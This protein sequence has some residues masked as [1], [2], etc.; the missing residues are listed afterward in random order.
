MQFPLLTKYKNPLKS[1]V[2]QDV[3]R[4]NIQN[5]ELLLWNKTQIK[6]EHLY[7]SGVYL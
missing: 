1:P 6:A 5:S 2:S 3:V 7:M 4:Q